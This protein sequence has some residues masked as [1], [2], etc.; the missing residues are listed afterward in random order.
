MFESKYSKVLTVILVIVIIAILGLL[1]FLGYDWYKKY[2]L[3][4][5]AMAFVDNYTE[6]STED[7]NNTT[8]DSNS[9]KTI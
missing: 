3:E 1:G 5:D 6:Y 4:N 7:K 8:D 2:F 9:T